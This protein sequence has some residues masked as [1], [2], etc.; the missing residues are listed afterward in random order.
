MQHRPVGVGTY[1]FA[2]IFAIENLRSGAARTQ[3]CSDDQCCRDVKYFHRV[4]SRELL[5]VCG[6]LLSYLIDA[7]F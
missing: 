6:A 5:Y 1:T 7:L 2:S 3:G 4:V